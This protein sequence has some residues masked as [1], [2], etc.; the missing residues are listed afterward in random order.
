M[1][2][3]NKL[4]ALQQPLKKNSMPAENKKNYSVYKNKDKS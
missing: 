1:E 2:K 4:I 3:R